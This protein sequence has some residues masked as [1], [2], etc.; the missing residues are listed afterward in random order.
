MLFFFIISGPGFMR[1]GTEMHSSFERY[2]GHS[3]DCGPQA[4]ED[5]AS[6]HLHEHFTGY[7][8]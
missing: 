4:L 6:D 2:D 7:A 5:V 8:Q 3:S 1:I